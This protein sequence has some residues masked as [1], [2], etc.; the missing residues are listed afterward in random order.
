MDKNTSCMLAELI[1]NLGQY[2]CGR[3]LSTIH[4]RGMVTNRTKHWQDK[5]QQQQQQKT[6]TLTNGEV[7]EEG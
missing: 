3:Q 2:N 5:Q 4:N 6:D 1:P 7:D